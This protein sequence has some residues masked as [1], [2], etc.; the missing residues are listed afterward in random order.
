MTHNFFNILIILAMIATLGALAFGLCVF[1]KGGEANRKYSNA[2][3]RWRIMLQA[4]A[5]FLFF[6]AFWLGR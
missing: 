1:F 6:I 2:A 4:L 3:M 5:L